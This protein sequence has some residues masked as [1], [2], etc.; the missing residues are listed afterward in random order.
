[1]FIIRVGV[2]V[3]DCFGSIHVANQLS[4]SDTDLIMVACLAGA[5]GVTLIIFAVVV[6]YW[7][8]RNNFNYLKKSDSN[9]KAPF[10]ANRKSFR[11]F[12]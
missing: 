7:R 11:F 6:V 9:K 4:F 5:A 2:K 12:C 3:E 1:M 8:S 10:N